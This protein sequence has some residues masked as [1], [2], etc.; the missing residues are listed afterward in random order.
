MNYLKQ[1]YAAAKGKLTTYLALGVAGFSQVAEHA[2][3]L[4]DSV[5]QL[6]GY[7]PQSKWIAT[8]T[9]WALTILGVLIVWSRV[10]RLLG[11]QA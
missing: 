1:L 11:P 6:S 3:D 2:Q 5:P 4:H 9:H 10:R 8:G 7:L